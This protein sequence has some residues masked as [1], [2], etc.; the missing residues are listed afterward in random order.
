MMHM[1]L[2]QSVELNGRLAA[3]DII[4]LVSVVSFCYEPS[5]ADQ[6]CSSFDSAHS[7]GI[8]QY[9]KELRTSAHL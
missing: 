2:W 6:A 8:I 9:H 3:L 5:H 4:I 7:L 1:L